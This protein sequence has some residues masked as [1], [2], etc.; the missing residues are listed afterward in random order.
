MKLD[1]SQTE[2]NVRLYVDGPFR[3]RDGEYRFHDWD[4]KDSKLVC[5]YQVLVPASTHLVLKTVLDGD[6]DVTG[7]AAEFD[8]RVVTGRA[9]LRK[10]GG[11]GQVSTI[12]GEL[13]AVFD[14]NPGDAC[15]FRTISGDVRVSFPQNLSADLYFK[16]FQGDIFTDFPVT[17]LPAVPVRRES[18]NGKFIY[19]V[20]EYY[21]VRVG[22]GGPELKFDTLNG[23]IEIHDRAL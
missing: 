19:R 6:I 21:R 18:R 2:N 20:N 14:R 3:Q 11:F 15:S 10:I 22:K 7:A 8:V 9:T 17:A 4:M 16:T 13:T 12:S 23:D 1:I 5:D